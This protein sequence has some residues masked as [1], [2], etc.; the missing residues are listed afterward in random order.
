MA[1]TYALR[2]IPVS[3]VGIFASNPALVT[4]SML[5]RIAS[6]LGDGTILGS[7]SQDEQVR[8]KVLKVT[9]GWAALNAAALVVD[10]RRERRRVRRIA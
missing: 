7:M 8:A 3:A 5:M 9:L 2:D 1:Y 4:A 6:D 10:R